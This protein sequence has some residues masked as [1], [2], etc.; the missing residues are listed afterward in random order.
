MIEVTGLRKS[1]RSKADW[2]TIF[3]RSS[4]RT[5][6]AG[7]NL[8]VERGE[9]FGLLGPNGAG[10]TTLI[11]ILAGLVLPDS[12][13]IRVDGLDVAGHMRQVRRLIGL[14]HGDE[15]SFFWRLS[16][17]ENLRF[18][19]CLYGISHRL[20]ERRIKELAEMVGLEAALD[21]EMHSYSSGMRQRA[22]FARGLIH[23][24]P[25]IVLDEPTR[26]LDPIGAHEIRRIVSERVSALGR[27]VLVAT[28]L[29]IE[30]ESLCDRLVLIDAG[31]AV[32]TGTVPELRSLLGDD[33]RYLITLRGTRVGA[34]ELCSVPGVLA[35]LTRLTDDGDLELDLTL[36]R[37]SAALAVVIRRLV[38]R[39]M[40]ITNCVLREP[41]LEEAFRTLIT[42]RRTS[43]A[44]VA[45]S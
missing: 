37:D 20:A 38:E 2:R 12:G 21:R 31:I 24:P 23:D 45:T 44:T 33:V 6:L 7:I 36:A 13:A 3:G 18:Y 22:A 19:A 30:A 34:G 10:K 15:R 40:E 8:T 9:V 43:R 35:M 32:F 26:S 14:V 5:V 17:R 39:G 16:L 41:T 1:F 25:L 27:T 42:Q 11:K 29:M 4:R 28:H